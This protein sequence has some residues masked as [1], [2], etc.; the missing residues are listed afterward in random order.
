MKV[1]VWSDYVCPFCYIGKRQLE[2]SIKDAGF[3]GQIEV[4]L[5]SYLLDPNTPVDSDKSVYASLSK[6]YNISEE[7]AKEMTKNVAERAQEVG[8]DYNFDI[9]TEANTIAA[10]RLAKWAN[11]IGKGAEL[12]ERLL[13][14]Y[15][16]EG[17]SIGKQ[18]VLLSLAG[19]V[20]L[21]QAEAQEILKGDQFLDEV[22]QD[23]S[24]AQ[25]LGVRGVP[26]F[27][28]DNKYGISGAQPKALFDQ[29]IAKAADEAGLKPKLRM[30]GEAGAVCTDDQCEF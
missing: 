6:K 21:E 23:I 25:D 3:E 2:Q 1:E 7:Q 5:K 14:S 9:M 4:V 13:K 15:F 19:D 8:L 16:L 29:T 26:F 30:V 11:T 27:V 24:E 28:V 22:Q 20:G 10:H 18:E 17:G 12:S